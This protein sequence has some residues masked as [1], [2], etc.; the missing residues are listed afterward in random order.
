MKHFLIDIHYTASPEVIQRIRPA[1]REFLHTGYDQNIL[2]MSGPKEPVTDGIAIARAN[3]QEE[4]Q[5]FFLQDPYALEKAA[6][7]T[8]Y[9][10][11]P[12]LYQSFIQDWITEE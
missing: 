11:S 8:I 6:I 2:L 9:E 12:V 4:I 5:N 7:H 3:S 1:H 10:F